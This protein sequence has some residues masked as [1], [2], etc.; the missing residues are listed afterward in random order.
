[1][2]PFHKRVSL[3]RSI[4]VLILLLGSDRGA[5][6]EIYDGF[7]TIFYIRTL[8]DFVNSPT[9]TSL[10]FLC[11]LPSL[12]SHVF[13]FSTHFPFF[14]C[15]PIF[16]LFTPSVHK[17]QSYKIKLFHNDVDYEPDCVSPPLTQTSLKLLK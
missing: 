7:P 9:F 4:T 11:P 14:K 16:L 3:C 8:T 12:L 10:L 2:Y 6:H 15:L 1:M 17:F 5:E 13:F